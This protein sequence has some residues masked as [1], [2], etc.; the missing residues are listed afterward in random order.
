MSNVPPKFK[1]RFSYELLLSEIEVNTPVCKSVNEA[2]DSIIE[3]RNVVKNMGKEY[4]FRLGISGTH[5]TAIP[6]EQL[7]VENDSYNWVSDQLQYYANQNITFAMHVHVAVPDAEQAIHI[8]NGLRHWVA[9]L[10]ALS[11]NSPFFGG[12]NT[13]FKST[14]TMQFGIFPRTEIP[15]KFDS[16]EEYESIINAFIDSNTIGKSRQVWWKLR[17][18]MD[19]GT[20]EFRMMDVQRSLKNT[21]MFTAIAQA[22]VYQSSLDLQNNKLLQDQSEVFLSDSLWKAARFGL[23]VKIID[24][25]HGQPI[26]MHQKIEKMI[27]YIMPAL[28]HFGNEKICGDIENILSN[29]TEGDQQ[30]SIFNKD[31]IEGLKKYLINNVQYNILQ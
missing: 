9:P 2:V 31:G 24:P 10:L 30:M 4:N 13:H 20:I 14:R 6:N 15:P 5:P 3:L 19:F 29:G 12:T 26:S 28:T 27:E 1:D 16:F 18:H 25:I 11:A 22:L 21:R 17:P 7:F 23:D 8:T